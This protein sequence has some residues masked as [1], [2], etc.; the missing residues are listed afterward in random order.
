V[1]L[2]AREH[3]GQVAGSWGASLPGIRGGSDCRGVVGACTGKNGGVRGG[4]VTVSRVV[5]VDG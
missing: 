3:R 5:G 2:A 1:S 4:L